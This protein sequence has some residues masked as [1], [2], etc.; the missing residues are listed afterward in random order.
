MSMQVLTDMALQWYLVSVVD[1]DYIN[2]DL[3]SHFPQA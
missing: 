3:F 2:G 1:N